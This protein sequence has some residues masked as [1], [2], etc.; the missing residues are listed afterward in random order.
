MMGVQNDINLHKPKKKVA[1]YIKVAKR[2]Y[3]CEE[4]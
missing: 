1:G 2:L 4:S 3:I